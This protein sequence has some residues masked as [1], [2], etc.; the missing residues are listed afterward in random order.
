VKGEVRGINGTLTPVSPAVP[1]PDSSL[2]PLLK[3]RGNSEP[4]SGFDNADRVAGAQDSALDYARADAAAFFHRPPR[5]GADHFLHVLHGSH[6][7]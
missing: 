2:G 7:S 1:E 4:R 5:A 6:K 3:G